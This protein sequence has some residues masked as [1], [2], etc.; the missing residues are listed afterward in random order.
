MIHL[1]M[2]ALM[3]SGL[4]WS[5]VLFVSVKH[6][7]RRQAAKQRA[8]V[9]DLALKI[10]ETAVAPETVYIPAAPRSGLNMSKR[11]QAMRMVRRNH[12]VSNIATALG[13]TRREVELLIRVQ[14]ISNPAA[15]AT[16]S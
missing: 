12:D 14:G 13:V 3:A 4:I 16:A 11:V 9:D 2:Y 10:E 8:K 5:L 15:K 7:I 6:E 1:V